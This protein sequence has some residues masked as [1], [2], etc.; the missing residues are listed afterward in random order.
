VSV[1][2]KLEGVLRAIE[3][4]V[5]NDS[6]KQWLNEL[7]A[8]KQQ[9]QDQLDTA[10]KLDTGVRLHPNAA[11]RRPATQTGS[12]A[13]ARPEPAHRP[14]SSS[15]S[16]IRRARAENPVSVAA[17]LCTSSSRNRLREK[18]MLSDDLVN[19]LQITYLGSAAQRCLALWA[20]VV[21]CRLL[22]R[23]LRRQRLGG[24]LERDD[25]RPNR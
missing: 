4:G 19:A 18:I 11:A 3:N 8:Q 15:M 22:G 25:A 10:A 23:S 17:G 21:N 6:L 1:N 9:L 13:A 7:E 16:R 5:W 14:S 20:L 12:V 2:R 24:S